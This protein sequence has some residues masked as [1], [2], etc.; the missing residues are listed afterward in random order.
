[1][2]N[3]NNIT[4]KSNEFSFPPRPFVS[5]QQKSLRKEIT[6]NCDIM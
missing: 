2:K 6:K 4:I 1:M 3:N 5:T